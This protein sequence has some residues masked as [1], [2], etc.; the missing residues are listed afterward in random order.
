MKKIFKG[1][2]VLAA[3]AA[4]GTGLALATGCG[5]ANETVVGYYAYDSWSNVYGIVVEVTVENNIITKVVD[6]TNSHVDDAGKGKIEYVIKGATAADDKKVDNT[7]WHVVSTAWEEYVF[8]P[9]NA[10]LLTDE[11]K[12]KI[13]ADPTYIPTPEECNF[14]YSWFNSD[15]K[16]W[17]TYEAW[18]L[19]Q[20]EGLSVAD[21]L[22]MKVNINNS[23]EPYAA[24]H[25]PDMVTNNLL[26]ANATQGSGRLLL[27]VQ[28]AL[29]KTVEIGRVK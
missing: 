26:I 25:N 11:I 22:D 17:N 13:A 20:Y 24:D 29:G 12:A 16:N 6:V 8:M 28:N 2:A 21:V 9:W 4:M 15:V 23:G 14:S 27:A 5:T 18:L 10:K 7:Q 3:T 19:Q 1:I